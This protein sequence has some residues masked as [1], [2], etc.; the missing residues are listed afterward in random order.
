PNRYPETSMARVGRILTTFERL[1]AG[2]WLP[3]HKNFGQ[4]P[5]FAR[6]AIAS[7]LSG[8]SAR[9]AGI[10]PQRNFTVK[11]SSKGQSA[12]KQPAFHPVSP[13]HP[14]YSSR[15]FAQD[16]QDQQDDLKGHGL[17]QTGGRREPP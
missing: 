14:V 3:G 2:A 8:Y 6:M 16:R 13:V 9:S 4:I 7:V 12:R 1:V 11:V 10:G 15:L 17:R 5:P